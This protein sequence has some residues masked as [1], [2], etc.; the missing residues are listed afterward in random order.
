MSCKKNLEE[1]NTRYIV[2][3]TLKRKGSIFQIHML[4]KIEDFFK[5]PIHWQYIDK[6]L[7]GLIKKET[8]NFE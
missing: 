4:E 2:E 5:L 6:L 3:Y 7:R 8:Q 1:R